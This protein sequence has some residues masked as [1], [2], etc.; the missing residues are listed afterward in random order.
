M[1]R[2]AQ[3]PDDLTF[4]WCDEPIAAVGTTIADSLP[5]EQVH[6]L[7][8]PLLILD[9]PPMATSD[10][11]CLQVQR[12]WGWLFVWLTPALPI[13]IAGTALCLAPYG[14]GLEDIPYRE[15][16]GSLLIAGGIAIGAA[17][18]RFPRREIWFD[19]KRRQLAILAGKTLSA[20][21][22]LT[23]AERI[24]LDGFAHV[25]LCERHYAPEIGDDSN[26]GRSEWIVSLE[27]PIPYA[28]ED[29]RVHSRSDAVALARFSGERRARRFAARVAY[30]AGL[31]ILEATDW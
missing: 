13:V 17:G 31:R 4:L 12:E 1:E 29:G 2:L 28:F 24:G 14:W 3:A 18:C 20:M 21:P 6:T 15:I 16:G 26:T 9:T 19:L 11:I 10:R 5:L 8:D 27:G 22:S 23:D 30:H 7:I 25:R